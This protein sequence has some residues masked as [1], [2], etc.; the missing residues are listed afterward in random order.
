M[1]MDH[2]LDALILRLLIINGMIGIPRVRM[3]GHNAHTMTHPNM[4]HLTGSHTGTSHRGHPSVMSGRPSATAPLSFGTTSVMPAF[5]HATATASDSADFLLE[6]RDALVKHD[7][8][9]VC[10]SDREATMA[11]MESDYGYYCTS[12]GKVAHTGD[13]VSFCDN[14][15][16]C[17]NLAPKSC[18]HGI[19][20]TTCFVK[21]D[22]TI[23][24]SQFE[25]IGSL[26]DAVVDTNGTLTFPRSL[27]SSETDLV[28][29]SVTL[30]PR[31]S[32]AADHD[33]AL[34]CADRDG[35]TRC[36]KRS[37]FCKSSG[38]VSYKLSDYFCDMVC[39]CKSLSKPAKGCVI[40]NA[41]KNPKI[42]CASKRDTDTLSVDDGTT[43][44]PNQALSKRD[45][46][47]DDTYHNYAMVCNDRK[48][49][50]ICASATYFCSANGKLT[51]KQYTHFC[52]VNCECRNL[53]R[54]YCIATNYVGVFCEMISHKTVQNETESNQALSKRDTD[55]DDMHH[56]Y[57]LVC[58]DK[59]GTNYCLTF[60][61]SCNANGKLIYQNYNR[62]CSINCKCVNLKRQYCIQTNYV[63]VFCEMVSKNTLQHE[64]GTFIG[65]VKDAVILPNGTFDF[66]HTHARRDLQLP[67]TSS[68]NNASQSS[69][70]SLLFC[71][72]GEH[73]R[74]CNQS[75]FSYCCHAS[76]LTA[77]SHDSVC[78]DICQCFDLRRSPQ[79]RYC[80]VGPN[81]T[82]HTECYVVGNSVYK[83]EGEMLTDFLGNFTDAAVDHNANLWLPSP[84]HTGSLPPN[85]FSPEPSAPPAV[86]ERDED[87][88]DETQVKW[89]LLC[90][91]KEHTKTCRGSPFAYT[92]DRGQ[93]TFKNW[94][95]V[96]QQI[97][98][99]IDHDPSQICIPTN[100]RTGQCPPGAEP[101]SPEQRDP[102]NGPKERDLKGIEAG[103]P[104]KRSA[105][106][107]LCYSGNYF[108]GSLTTHCM[109]ESYTC[110]P[111]SPDLG[112]LFPALAWSGP[113][114]AQ[115]SQGCRCRAPYASADLSTRSPGTDDYSLVCKGRRDRDAIVPGF[116][117]VIDRCRNRWGYTCDGNGHMQHNGT[118]VHQC[119]TSCSCSNIIHNGTT[120]TVKERSE[121][122]DK[123]E[124]TVPDFV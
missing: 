89:N 64:N 74:T 85:M 88:A 45:T 24:N 39:E 84:G 31:D 27:P 83:I 67:A 57:A 14:G 105:Y 17:V 63:G 120:H 42:V 28:P 112:R 56:D 47:I 90:I 44:E 49:T 115:C 75:P 110:N 119:D 118:S 58:I 35:T 33:W 26:G 51:Y 19:V 107:I 61:Y 123:G 98:N 59:Q 81:P 94:D 16:Q 43:S 95:F 72:N 70:R 91:N 60:P 101:L 32:D 41:D 9:L 25:V 54:Q 48:G 114:E 78:D 62:F 46:D 18:I 79:P 92:C 71:Q 20:L 69:G 82:N 68:E 15:C 109:A 121:S 117:D 87:D 108:N 113:G 11:C 102:P 55:I 104:S 13:K 36:E 122:L 76:N 53:Q 34:I 30:S 8:A 4:P 12:N 21:V 93:M 100:T 86:I 77:H 50:S 73:T 97:C 7:Y 106:H 1:V 80:T 38:Q 96:C 116:Q 6:S 37:Y 65:N 5:P 29:A 22:G 3:S 99:C 52:S 124:W 66:S 10:E 103:E 40:V 2:H 111:P 23:V